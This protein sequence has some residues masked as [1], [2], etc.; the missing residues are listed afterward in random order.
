MSKLIEQQ[1][2]LHIGKEQ[3]AEFDK[4][5]PNDPDFEEIDDFI[6]EDEELSGASK[7]IKLS[8][9]A[10]NFNM[11]FALQNNNHQPQRISLLSKAN[12]IMKGWCGKDQPRQSQLKTNMKKHS[13]A[14][15][16]LL[17]LILQRQSSRDS[18]YMMS[19]IDER[20]DE[21]SVSANPKSST[22][23]SMV[24]KKYNFGEH[25]TPG[26]QSRKKRVF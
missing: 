14:T 17:N 25:Y 16:K 1:A 15:S 5:S 3:S 18:D 4:A 7:A 23:P 22:R 20:E 8:I 12:G 11:M 9:R 21:D 26:Q 24:A 2:A 10:L 6:E 13:S 19:K